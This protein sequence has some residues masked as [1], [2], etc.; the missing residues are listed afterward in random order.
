MTDFKKVKI[1]TK[2]LLWITNAIVEILMFN[3]NNQFVDLTK[4]LNKDHK[5][6]K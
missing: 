3:K 6:K 5:E 2:I 1:N 4:Q